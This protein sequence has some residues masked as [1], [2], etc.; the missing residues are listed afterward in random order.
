VE[1]NV[2]QQVAAIRSHPWL[3]RDVP[4]HGLIYEVETGRLRPVE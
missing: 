3:K 1:E 2:R 4:V